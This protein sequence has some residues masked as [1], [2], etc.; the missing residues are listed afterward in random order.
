[1]T[2]NASVDD[3]TVA[4]S[5]NN[6]QIISLAMD[7]VQINAGQSTAAF[8]GVV[9]PA[10]G[11]VTIS[12]SLGADTQ[13]TQLTVLEP[14]PEVGPVFMPQTIN[15]P[16]LAAV[17][18][19]RGGPIFIPQIINTPPLAAVGSGRGGPV[20]VPQVINTPPLEAVGGGRND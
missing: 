18:S 9:G 3:I 11:T 13:T 20:F 10:V 8:S 7:Q 4:L 14:I 19:G 12:A 1:M 15:T 6:S 5:T 16:P 17:G 2:A